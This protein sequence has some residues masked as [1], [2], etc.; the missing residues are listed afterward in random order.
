MT[1]PPTRRCDTTQRT[2]RRRRR[3]GPLPLATAVV[4]VVALAA[5]PPCANSLSSPAPRFQVASQP[6][7]AALANHCFAALGPA[8]EV[9]ALEDRFAS[10]TSA[11]RKP[12]GG[13]VTTTA[14]EARTPVL[15]RMRSALVVP[16]GEGFPR[17]LNVVAWPRPGLDLPIFAADLVTLPNGHLFA[18]DLHPTAT[19]AGNA[20]ALKAQKQAPASKLPPGGALPPEVKPFFSARHVW[21]R[22]P[23][24]ADG[25]AEAVD[26]TLKTYLAAYLAL[27][28]DA[29]QCSP[30]DA[31]DVAARQ[32]AYSDYR[33]SKDPARP[34]FSALYGEDWTESFIKS[35]LFPR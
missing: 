5:L 23:L 4:A 3:S 35:F 14:R 24:D 30:S 21:S 13:A 17:V 20:R 25:V 6:D 8:A 10:A 29:P 33:R 9:V 34:M 19:D 2:A 31:A 11:P 22:V 7:Y 15:A 27:A 18:F 1:R 28:D 32:C 12:G 16:E 26:E